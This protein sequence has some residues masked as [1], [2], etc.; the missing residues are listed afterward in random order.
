MTSEELDEISLG[1]NYVKD[2]GLSRSCDF[3]V[4]YRLE[5]YLISEAQVFNFNYGTLEKPNWMKLAKKFPQ[6]PKSSDN[7][8]L[9]KF[10]T[11]LRRVAT[12]REVWEYMLKQHKKFG[13]LNPINKE[14]LDSKEFRALESKEMIQVLEKIVDG[15]LTSQKSVR[16]SSWFVRYHPILKLA[17][18]K[19]SRRLKKV[20]DEQRERLV[21]GFINWILDHHGQE[22]ISH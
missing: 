11:L 7:S 15:T 22:L 20:T 4:L 8:T 21:Q 13:E 9:K 12:Q 2:S 19:S 16:V 10:V 18:E 17:V 1:T 6:F 3:E 14:K 5:R